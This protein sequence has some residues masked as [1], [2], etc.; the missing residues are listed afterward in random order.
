MAVSNERVVKWSLTKG[1]VNSAL[2]LEFVETLVTDQRDVLLMDNASIHKTAAVIDAIVERGL[3]P[4]FLPPYT[5]EFQPIEHCFFLLKNVYR[6]LQSVSSEADPETDETVRNRLERSMHALT[7]QNLAAAFG[8]CWRRAG[9]V[10]KSHVSV[11]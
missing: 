4:C 9:A 2:F 10:L 7:P 6:R 8:A 5:P 3:T 1:S 11:A